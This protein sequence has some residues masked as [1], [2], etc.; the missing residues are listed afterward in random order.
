M[1]YV[2]LVLILACLASCSDKKKV[3]L[4]SVLQTIGFKHTM[5]YKGDT[6]L[7]IQYNT[8]I[9]RSQSDSLGIDTIIRKDVDSLAYDAD[10]SI[11][12]VRTFSK[13]SEYGH[14][15]YRKYYFNTD[16]LLT[17]VTRF[18]EAGEYTTDSISYDYTTKT[19]SLYDLI[20]K[21]CVKL[22]YD[23]DFNISSRV[24]KRIESDH[25]V[26]TTYLYYNATRDPFLINLEDD[27]LLFGCFNRQ[28]VGLF[29]NGGHAM[30][31]R[32]KNNVQAI[33]EVRYDG[34]S[35]NLFEY[36]MKDGLPTAQYGGYGAVYYHYVAVQ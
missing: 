16:L 34:E 1:R 3:R 9:S 12:L 33:K 25:V 13:H 21:T 2:N 30:E 27:E 26:S 17:R 22:E 15:N 6:L 23:R 7:R 32:S 28:S 24:E 20:N 11:R 18:A 14:K 4:S 31:I 35:N 36:Q 5:S 19:A 29:W 10:N 8:F